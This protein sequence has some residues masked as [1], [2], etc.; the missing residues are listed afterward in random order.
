MKAA[1]HT[2]D[3]VPCSI[4]SKCLKEGAAPWNIERVLNLVAEL[5]GPVD[6]VLLS[7]VVEGC[8]RMK[9]LDLLPKV[10][11]QFKKQDG[12]LKLSAPCYGSL[13]KAY[14]HSGDVSRMWELWSEMNQHNIK[15]TAI[16]LGCM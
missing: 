14:G 3:A 1:G 9:R 4:L 5:G 15:A 8:I 13:I 10:M 7:S 2:P 12:C 11:E 16:T 6:E